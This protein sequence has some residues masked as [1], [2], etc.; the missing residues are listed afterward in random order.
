MKMG[1]RGKG[2]GNGSLIPNPVMGGA[3]RSPTWTRGLRE[4]NGPWHEL[5]GEEWGTGKG[6]DDGAHSYLLWSR[7]TGGMEAG[8]GMCHLEERKEGGSVGSW[9]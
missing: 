5:D 7:E 3:V 8:S 1:K 4:E 6:N 2:G 9:R